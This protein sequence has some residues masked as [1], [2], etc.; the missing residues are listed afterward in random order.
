MP[1]NSS[2]NGV[3][4][5]GTY[6]TASWMLSWK[7]NGLSTQVSIIIIT[8]N[9]KCGVINVHSNRAWFGWESTKESSK[10]ATDHGRVG[11]WWGKGPSGNPATECNVYLTI[12]EFGFCTIWRIM[13]IEEGFIRRG[14]RPSRKTT[15]RDLHNFSDDTK[16]ESNNCFIIHSK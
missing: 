13:E 15:L 12:I 16:A 10:S 5:T 4:K 11:Q 14:H 1:R 9:G 6:W 7:L 3:E 2:T 8:A